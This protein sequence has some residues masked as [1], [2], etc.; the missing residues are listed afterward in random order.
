MTIKIKPPIILPQPRS[1]N[2]FKLLS[3]LLH[4][5]YTLV[6]PQTSPSPTPD[7]NT[8]TPLQTSSPFPTRSPHLIH[9]KCQHPP[10]PYPPPKSTILNTHSKTLLQPPLCFSCSSNLVKLNADNTCIYYNSLIS[11]HERNGMRS[12]Y[13]AIRSFE[14]RRNEELLVLWVGFKGVWDGA[15]REKEGRE[16]EVLTVCLERDEEGWLHVNLIWGEVDFGDSGL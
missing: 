9:F 13:I 16:G 5:L 15:R 6:R 2:L 14:I 3:S 11:W 1:K 4:F 10:S 12:D 7:P 8:L